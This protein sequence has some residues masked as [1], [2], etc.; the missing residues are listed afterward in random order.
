[1]Q[2]KSL[3]NVLDLAVVVF[4]IGLKWTRSLGVIRS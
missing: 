2:L 3:L 4:F 1:M